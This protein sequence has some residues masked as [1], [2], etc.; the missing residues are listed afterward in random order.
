MKTWLSRPYAPFLTALGLGLAVLLLAL[1]VPLW[2]WWRGA[3][4]AQVAAAGTVPAPWA[5]QVQG[6]VVSLLGLQL[7]GSRWGE[8]AARWGDG[9]QLAVMARR[10]QAGRLEAYIERVDAGGVLGRLVLVFDVPDD[11]LRALQQ[12]AAKAEAVDGVVWRHVMRGEQRQQLAAVPV[13]SLSFVVSTRLDAATLRQR[14]GAPSQRWLEAGRLRHW[15]YPER[16]LALVLDPEGRHVLQAVPPADFD[17]SLR[18]PLLASG[19]AL[20]SADTPD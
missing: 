10:D 7:P 19:A 20:L 1:A 17:A 9:V 14:Y 15:L 18:A 2:T 3:P 11:T 16:G 12:G 13:R 4:P 5:T 6:G 8:V